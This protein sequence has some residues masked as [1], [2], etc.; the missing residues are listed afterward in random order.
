M[1]HFITCWPF[2]SECLCNGLLK[3]ISFTHQQIILG[4]RYTLKLCASLLPACRQTT[5]CAI[6]SPQPDPEGGASWLP[7]QPAGVQ[8]PGRRLHRQQHGQ[9]LQPP[10]R[11]MGRR[12]QDTQV[13]RFIGYGDNDFDSVNLHCAIS[14]QSYDTVHI[15]RAPCLSSASK[16]YID[17]NL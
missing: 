11:Q 14:L 15:Q 16:L 8:R 13:C 17:K 2:F 7:C 1:Y 10:Q 12:G 4:Q 3:C 6:P 9:P 5:D